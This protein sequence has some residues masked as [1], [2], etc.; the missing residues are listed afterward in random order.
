MCRCI[1]SRNITI[2]KTIPW[3][4]ADLTR[5][6]RERDYHHCLAK[7]TGS[8]NTYHKFCQLRNK[9][10]SMVSKAKH[11]FLKTIFDFIRTLKQFWSM[12]HSLTPNQEC[13]PHSLTNGVLTASSPTSKANLLNLFFVSCFTAIMILRPPSSPSESFR[14][15]NYSIY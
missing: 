14:T 9:A 10:V 15:L 11:T 8:S 4:D 1:P 13:I 6:L 5:L 2:K 12:Y 3:L 7:C